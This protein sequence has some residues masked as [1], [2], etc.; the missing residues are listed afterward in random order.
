MKHILTL[1]GLIAISVLYLF[2]VD[3]TQLTTMNW[4]AFAIILLTVIYVTA[5]VVLSRERHKQA[6][7]ARQQGKQP[8]TPQP[9]PPRQPK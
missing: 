9:A 6:K 8:A 2:E 1:V 4:V 3:Y 5:T 7:Q